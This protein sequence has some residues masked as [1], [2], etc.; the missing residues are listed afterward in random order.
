M[1]HLLV[2]ILL[3]LSTTIFSQT[4]SSGV[5]IPKLEY[6]RLAKVVQELRDSVSLLNTQITYLKTENDILKRLRKND[7]Q[8]VSIMAKEREVY[9]SIISNYQQSIAI[10]E[11]KWYENRLLWFIGGIVVTYTSSV[12]IRNIK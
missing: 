2:I 8:M 11:P 9:A 10:I 7:E 12:I 1:K 4:D 3:T 6:I 5:Y